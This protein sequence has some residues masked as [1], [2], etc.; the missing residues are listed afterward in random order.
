MHTVLVA[1]NNENLFVDI[2]IIRSNNEYT[3]KTMSAEFI[4]W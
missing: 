3:Y 2:V 1:F 4:E